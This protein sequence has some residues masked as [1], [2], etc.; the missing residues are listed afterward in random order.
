MCFDYFS[1]AA[2]VR[3][4]LFGSNPPESVLAQKHFVG[5]EVKSE[6]PLAQQGSV[7]Q[8]T[9]QFVMLTSVSHYICY[10]C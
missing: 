2:V 10:K 7:Y 5:E 3:Q 4:R 1:E 6:R 9:L 8:A